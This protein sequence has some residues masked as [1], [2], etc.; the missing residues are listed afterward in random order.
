VVRQPMQRENFAIL[1][2]QE[3]V[4]QGA[5]FGVGDALDG[6]GGDDVVGQGGWGWWCGVVWVEGSRWHR[7]LNF[8]LAVLQFHLY[9]D[10]DHLAV[11]KYAANNRERALGSE[12][13]N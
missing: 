6:F 2:G 4:D 11:G 10:V 7:R 5:C 9:G 3:G 13:H 8:C 1:G 12:T